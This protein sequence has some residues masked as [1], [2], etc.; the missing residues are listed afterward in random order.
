MTSSVIGC[1]FVKSQ[2]A[3]PG[4]FVQ[5]QVW[6]VV[7]TLLIAL[8]SWRIS[9]SKTYCRW[10]TFA[11]AILVSFGIN[12]GASNLES[13]LLLVG[14]IN[15]SQWH[16]QC[17]PAR[18]LGWRRTCYATYVP[19]LPSWPWP[20]PCP[21]SLSPPRPRPRPRPK[22]QKAPPWTMRSTPTTGTRS[23]GKTLWVVTMWMLY[24][25]DVL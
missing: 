4:T 16:P 13:R 1:D 23:T 10:H 9:C 15:W 11:L 18:A 8:L 2:E 22:G 20:T 25:C 19:W 7:E 24:T 5:L 17:G 14:T 6:S 3:V 12:L 21:P